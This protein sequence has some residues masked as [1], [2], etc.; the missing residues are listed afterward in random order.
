MTRPVGI[1]SQ[2]LGATDTATAAANAKAA[3]V[4]CVNVHRGEPDVFFGLTFDAARAQQVGCIYRDAG[5]G[6]VGFAA[7]RDIASPDL[8]LRERELRQFETWIRLAPHL[9]TDLVATEAGHWNH[10]VPTAHHD[11]SLSCP[12]EAWDALVASVRRLDRAAAQ[13]GVRL[14]F[15]IV[16]DTI[17]DSPDRLLALIEAVGSP[18]LGAVLDPANLLTWDTFDRRDAVIDAGVA[19]L[20]GRIVLAHGKDFGADGRTNVGRGAIDFARLHRALSAAGY[21]GPIVLEKLELHELP[22]SVELL[23]RACA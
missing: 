16:V 6:V 8:E 19:K 17:L 21:D 7:Y 3:G 5:L 12:L 2:F 22:D 18:R 9:G 15:E 10:L 4:D 13:E 20:S 11:P 14:G 23:R 1:F